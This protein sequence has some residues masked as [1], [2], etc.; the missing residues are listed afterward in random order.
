MSDNIHQLL[1]NFVLKEFVLMS[2]YSNTKAG[3]FVKKAGYLSN[4]LRCWRYKRLS[5]VYIMRS[6][7]DLVESRLI[8]TRG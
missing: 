5:K 7:I 4:N 2:F 3:A 6:S 8:D 1:R